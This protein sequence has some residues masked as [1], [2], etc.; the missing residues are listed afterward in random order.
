MAMVCMGLREFKQSVSQWVEI[1]LK[2]IFKNIFSLRWRY[3]SKI[4]LSQGK[5]NENCYQFPSIMIK[6]MEFRALFN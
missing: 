6:F 2:I 4:S 3:L 1:T 5:Y